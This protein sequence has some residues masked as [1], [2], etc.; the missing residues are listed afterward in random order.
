MNLVVKTAIFSFIVQ[1]ISG[2]FLIMAFFYEIKKGDLILKTIVS[3][4]LIVQILEGIF[5]LFIIKKF[6]KG[7]FDTSF[8]YYDWFLSTPTM[9]ISTMLFLIYLRT[10]PFDKKEG[11]EEEKVDLDLKSIFSNNKLLI[12]G[13]VGFNALMLILGYLGE[14]GKVSK[15]NAFIYGTL[16]LI[17]SF[18][19][20]S[21]FTK[22]EQYGNIFVGIM[23][24]IWSLYGI[25]FLRPLSEKNIWYNILD[26]F[27][28]NFYGVFLYVIMVIKYGKII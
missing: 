13:I 26:L 5:Y 14:K 1:V 2:I 20:L 11:L 15:M 4:E 6:S 21:K 9:L 8:R 19:C 22:N 18:G 27:S 23:F 10:K 16:F 7:N 25:A 28:K 3:L 12:T 17:I 24:F